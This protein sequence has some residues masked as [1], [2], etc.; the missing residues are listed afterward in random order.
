MFGSR[1]WAGWL[2]ASAALALGL[3]FGDLEAEPLQRTEGAVD[4]S[5]LVGGYTV[6]SARNHSINLY[7]LKGAGHT[8]LID[9]LWRPS[10]ARRALEHLKRDGANPLSAILITHAHTDHVGGLPVFLE[11]Y[12]DAKVYGDEITARSLA[13]D[14]QGFAA[15]RRDDFKDDFPK[16]LPTPDVIIDDGE[17]L[18]FGDLTIETMTL[19]SNE[20]IATTVFYFA[21]DGA[22]FTGD[23]VNG[24]TTPV[25]YQGGIDAWIDQ[26]QEL[27]NRFPEAVVIYPGHGAPGP[28]DTLIE[29]QI[30]YLSTFRDLLHRALNDDGVVTA[31]ERLSIADAT[32]AAF[33]DWRTSAGVGARRQ[34]IDLNITW[35][36]RGWRV[37]GGASSDP[38]EFRRSEG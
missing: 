9:A 26:L 33:P 10:E 13:H 15:N 31:G 7:W 25:F 24:K 34:L 35:V 16:D 4:G 22:L 36:L 5:A 14:E 21:K 30:S 11:A 17:A 2:G 37:K 1:R 32:E 29:A 23:L 18:T 28:A 38:R 19:R 6:D 3:V 8:V 20:A 12:P 27:R